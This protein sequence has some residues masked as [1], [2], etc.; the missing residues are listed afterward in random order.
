MSRHAPSFQ[1]SSPP[2][3]R[4]RNL[5]AP[6]RFAVRRRSS[7][8]ISKGENRFGGLIGWLRPSPLV[9]PVHKTPVKQKI[10][11]RP[12]KS[13]RDHLPQPPPVHLTPPP[14]FY[15]AVAVP[16]Q[17]HPGRLR[18]YVLCTQR[19]VSDALGGCGPICAVPLPLPTWIAKRSLTA[20]AQTVASRAPEHLG[21]TPD[22]HF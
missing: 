12:R 15:R 6:R 21:V 2:K 4:S 17:S 13:P 1:F 14:S 8:V 10:D 7:L 20:W 11:L 3:L 22:D 18:N 9:Y 5:A 19:F 16:P